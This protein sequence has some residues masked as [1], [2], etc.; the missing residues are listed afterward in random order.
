[1]TEQER[2]LP[3]VVWASLST[4]C[5]KPIIY[6]ILQPGPDQVSGVP[7]VRPSEILN[8]EIDLGALR[9][10]TAGIAARYGRST[11]DAGDV[12]L[13]IVG[14]IGKVAIVPKELT[15]GNITQS[16]VRLSP[17]HAVISS[18][19]LAWFLRSPAATK[20]FNRL[21]LGTGVPRLNVGDVR[22]ISVPLRSLNDQERI[23]E[24]IEAL[25]TRSRRAREALEALP[26]LLDRY[27]ASV[28]AAAFRGDLT[29]DWREEHSGVNA[30]DLVASTP[31]PQ[32]PR[33]GRTAAEGV[34][35]GRA[36]LSVNNPQTQLPQG[37]VWTPLL[38]I[39]RQE[40][41]H[42]PSRSV[43]AYWDGDI[44]WIG[45]RDAGAHHGTVIDDT[46][47][48]V[49]QAGLDNSSA[50]L[51]PAGTVCLS[52][53]A[54]VG[55]VVIMG[56]DMATSQDFVTWTCSEALEPKFL[57]YALLAE[58]EDIRRFGKGST[59]TTIY[60]PE[61]RA[62]HIALPP[63]EEQRAIVARVEAALSPLKK[64]REMAKAEQD[65]LNT[66]DQSILAKAFRGELVP[67]D[68]ADEPA[69]ALLNRIRARRATE[70]PAPRRGRRRSA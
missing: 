26:A 16:S 63:L 59:H 52:R 61:V 65:R 18:Q 27:R 32:Q 35:A 36:A 46:F 1:M 8:N 2:P 41:G 7:Y 66:L 53:T 38:R 70:G 10:T 5:Q 4:I 49:T 14:T 43:P 33:G 44:P 67:Q 48:H 15:G 28:L 45:I 20:Q 25:T 56:R 6:G 37:W 17:E 21:R 24:K 69:S 62:M 34:T 68:P 29:K 57:M 22:E 19:Y 31:A 40:T 60:F 47:Q 64:L 9:S 39:A 13:S 11:L 58:G 50:R 42:T 23:V 55:Y 3:G 30:T 12:L 51:L 54:S